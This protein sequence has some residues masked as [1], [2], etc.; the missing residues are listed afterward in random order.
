[1]SQY[2]IYTSYPNFLKNFFKRYRTQIPG[3]K[4]YLHLKG[5]DIVQAFLQSRHHSV[6]ARNWIFKLLYA[7]EARAATGNHSIFISETDI[8]RLVKGKYE[9][10]SIPDDLFPYEAFTVCFPTSFK[11]CGKRLPG[12]QVS[13]TNNEDSFSKNALAV[14]KQLPPGS[15]FPITLPAGLLYQS[16]ELTVTYIEPGD[17]D[18]TFVNYRGADLLPAI[19]AE[20]LSE[21][22][23]HTLKFDG[24]QFSAS[25]LNDS[26]LERQYVILR[27]ILGMCIYIKAR[28]EALVDGFPKVKN[29]SLTAPFSTQTQSMSLELG[30]ATALRSSP[31]EHYRSWHIRQLSHERYYRNEHKDLAPGSRL[32]FVSD[33]MVNSTATVKSVD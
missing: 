3:F 33:T 12:V 20:S 8:E 13:F 32:V 24:H 26:E 29:F 5:M 27:A 25:S 7:E 9:L 28:P 18:H 19:N 14:M 4:K 31:N 15:L 16:C 2:S 22:K 11:V 21:Y 23:K 10:D 1:M 6:G 17:E 30:D